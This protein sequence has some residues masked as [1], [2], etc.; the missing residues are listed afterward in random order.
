MGWWSQ[1]VNDICPLFYQTTYSLQLQKG[2]FKIHERVQ[3]LRSFFQPFNRL[4][5]IFIHY[6]T[7]PSM[8][9]INALLSLKYMGY[10]EGF[11]NTDH[12]FRH[13]T[14]PLQ[15]CAAPVSPL[16]SLPVTTGEGGWAGEV[17]AVGVF[18]GSAK[19][20]IKAGLFSLC[21]HLLH[22]LF[23]LG[24]HVSSSLPPA[25]IPPFMCPRG[26]DRLGADRSTQHPGLMHARI[27]VYTVHTL[28]HTQAWLYPVWP[29][30]TLILACAV[31]I[32][33]REEE[34]IWVIANVFYWEHIDGTTFEPVQPIATVYI[35]KPVQSFG[36]DHYC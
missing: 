23:E 33:Q 15:H 8:Q 34:G 5:D 35:L 1:I 6:T 18:P 20:N 36:Q 32:R 3:R 11:F 17:R 31:H 4:P 22:H 7:L 21:L 13:I 28:M 10:C 19:V 25:T 16:A 29:H 9:S 27:H 14:E 12:R 26:S 2:Y 24:G 30:E